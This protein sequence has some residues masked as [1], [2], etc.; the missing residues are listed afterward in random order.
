MKDGRRLSLRLNYPSVSG[1][2][3]QFAELI[4]EQLRQVGIELRLEGVEGAVWSERRNAS[5]FD[6]D[7]ATA[8]MDPSPSGIAQSW[9]CAGIGGSNVGS[10]CNPA[11]DT[12]LAAAIF[13]S[14]Q[15]LPI[16]R[17][18]VDTIQADAPAVFLYTPEVVFGIHRRYGNVKLTPYSYWSHIWQW[19]VSPGASMPEAAASR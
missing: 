7:L 2:R 17:A 3:T 14:S 9:S 8:G 4:Q 16:W 11:V 18:L 12:L 1:T 19:T 10:Y 13:A 6:M 5:R 15:A